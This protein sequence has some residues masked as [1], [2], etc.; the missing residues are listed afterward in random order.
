MQSQD[1]FYERR[2]WSSSREQ[3]V[4]DHLREWT[5]MPAGTI[6]R[7]PPPVP[8][9]GRPAVRNTTKPGGKPYV[10]GI[11]DIVRLDDIYPGA[12]IDYSGRQSGYSSTEQPAMGV[13]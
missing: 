12:R 2:P 1:S 4:T 11:D 8:N 9:V 5:D 3:Q 7:L 13:I 10:I 6:R